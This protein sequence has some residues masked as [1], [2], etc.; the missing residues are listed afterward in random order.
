MREAVLHYKRKVEEEQGLRQWIRTLE[1]ALEQHR[2]LKEET[3]TEFTPFRKWEDMMEPQTERGV[4]AKEGILLPPK[5]PHVKLD[6]EKGARTSNQESGSFLNE[7]ERSEGEMR[8]IKG[9]FDDK[10]SVEMQTL[11][12]ELETLKRENRKLAE[13]YAKKA[14]QLQASH[15]IDKET[16]RKATQQ[17][18]ADSCQGWP[19]RDDCE[20]ASQQQRRKMEADLETKG[21]R[22]FELTKHSQKLKAAMQ[23][24]ELQLKEARQANAESKRTMKTLEEELSFV[25]ERL[26]IQENGLLQKTEAMETALN[27]QSKTR[28]E[29]GDSRKQILHLRQPLPSKQSPWG[30]DL[31]PR[32]S[33][34]RETEALTAQHREELCK[35]KQASDEEKILLKEQLA[36][37]LEDLAKKHALELKAAQA[38]MDA[39]RKEPQKVGLSYS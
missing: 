23:D 27:S 3:S 32:G 7:Q 15:E 11:M 2:Q 29:A 33:A 6:P 20:A 26:L 34:S 21:Q 12:R 28:D 30:K 39:H 31:N 17:S 10:S 24:L 36:K 35:T 14:S 5:M 25:K 9:N 38:A 16:Q 1:E 4:C 22:I 18:G 19:Q 13:E 37:G 8:T